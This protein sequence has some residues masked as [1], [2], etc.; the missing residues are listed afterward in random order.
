MELHAHSYRSE[1]DY[2]HM[3]RLLVEVLGRAGL[4]VY[5]TIGDI[6]WWRSADENPESLYLTRLWFDG[7]QPVA[8]AWP[9]DDQVDIVI[10]PDYPTL[11]DAALAWA[12]QEYRE[13][14]GEAPEK[15]MRAWGFTNDSARIN[16]LSARGYRRTDT[17]LVCYTRPVSNTGT[18]ALPAGYSFDHVHGEADVTRRTA[19]QRAAF[20]S[21]FM[22]DAKTRAVQAMPTYRAE[23]DLV[24]IAPDSSYAAF[25]II[26]LDDTNHV[27]VFEPLGVAAAHRRRGLGRAILGEGVRRLGQYGAHIACVQTGIDNSPARALYEAEGFSELDRAH[28]W[29]LAPHQ[30]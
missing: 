15:P 30:V 23:L 5:A 21:T 6:D 12:E 22:T 13:R 8:F 9:V 1:G 25:T 14:Q 7:E 24:I 11:H 27:G 4:P 2:G 28:A 3:R 29:T 18:P 20:E 26:W 10:H 17:G 16:A 19:V